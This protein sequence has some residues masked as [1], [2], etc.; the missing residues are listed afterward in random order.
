M[1]RVLY[2]LWFFLIAHGVFGQT[3]W[4]EA[5]QEYYHLPITEAGIYRLE[6]DALSASGLPMAEIEAHEWELWVEG[7]AVPIYY[8]EDGGTF[9]LEFV[10]SA[11]DGKLDAQLLSGGRAELL[12]PSYSMFSDTAHYYLSWAEDAE[13]LG[14]AVDAEEP[15]INVLRRLSYLRTDH[16]VFGD[17]WV[18]PYNKIGG[19]NIYLSE[20]QVG[21]GFAAER[22]RSFGE[23]LGPVQPIGGQ[24]GQ[25]YLRFIGDFGNHQF[26][27]SLNGEEKWAAERGSFTL[28]QINLN[29]APGELADSLSYRLEGQLDNR[30]RFYLA[31]RKL[32]Y[33]SRLAG[34]RP[35]LEGR[36]DTGQVV[37]D[38][39]GGLSDPIVYHDITNQIRYVFTPQAESY[40]HA[41]PGA[42]DFHYARES[43]VRTLPPPA[44]TDID[45]SA[46]DSES[47]YIIITGKRLDGGAANPAIQAYA[48]YRSSE[49]GGDYQV[50]LVNVEDLYFK[51]GYGK[52]RHPLAI[53]NFARHLDTTLQR[54][55]LVF[56]IGKGREYRYI[57]PPQALQSE[58]HRGFSVP[59]YGYPS[60]DNLMM[61]AS[62]NSAPLFPLGRLAVESEAGIWSYLDKVKQ[63]EEQ[64]GTPLA[65]NA[66]WRKKMVHL[67][68][69][70]ELQPLITNYMENMGERLSGSSWNPEL[71]TF[72]RGSSS[73][74]ERPLT[75]EIYDEINA[76]S[77]WVTFFGHSATNSLGFDINI[78][79]KYMNSPRHPFLLALGCYGGN[80]NTAQSSVGEIY[81]S[82]EGGGFIG[83]IATSGPGEVT[84]LYLFARR[85]YDELGAQA[86]ERTLA[87][88]F[89]AALQEREASDPRHVQQLMYFGDPALRI[90]EAKGPDYTFDASMTRI[91]PQVINVGQDSFHVEV[92]ILNLGR[93]TM[94]VL[95]LRI[96]RKGPLGNVL[97]EQTVEL[98][99]PGNRVQLRTIWPVGGEEGAGLNRLE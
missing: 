8:V 40:L 15:S 9:Y 30:D 47:N 54:Q 71:K 16:A 26:S 58:A 29:L 43:A 62:G 90:Y 65:E 13:G 44:K 84:R 31:E 17:Q 93:S 25:L 42:H 97:D 14:Q 23:T 24:S 52:A 55:P 49:D 20:F 4:W 79:S 82:F 68:G 75:D 64:L 87:Q 53:R 61:A 12:N 32:I 10:A 2:G 99:A 69:G 51:Y 18:K 72:E 11:P 74:T 86:D 39:A 22:A 70:G 19:A 45:F 50:E 56:I 83:S 66:F 92:D 98:D 59:T 94:E 3:G 35:M 48:E 34:N 78:P 81:S 41:S 28:E 33:P 1:R 76:G 89:R 73:S 57:R 37:L 5:D 91:S 46:I 96:V 36:M 67:V 38:F 77:S 85:F 6:A 63:Q 27:I 60:S 95:P 7:E 80:I 21:E 88:I